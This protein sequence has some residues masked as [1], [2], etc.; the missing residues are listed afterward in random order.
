MLS[1]LQTNNRPCGRLF[2]KLLAGFWILAVSK[3]LQI[4]GAGREFL[5]AYLCTTEEILGIATT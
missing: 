2:E 4:R 3:T 5:E 1:A